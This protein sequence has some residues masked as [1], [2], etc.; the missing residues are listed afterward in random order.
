MAKRQ[1]PIVKAAIRTGVEKA[2]DQ[3]G[4][5]TRESALM[6]NSFSFKSGRC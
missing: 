6:T 5:V 2:A 4:R 1:E 3:A